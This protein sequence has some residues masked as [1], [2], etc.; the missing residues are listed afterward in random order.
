MLLSE[1]QFMLTPSIYALCKEE[2]F[3]ER[4]LSKG[5][6]TFMLNFLYFTDLSQDVPM[7]SRF[8]NIKY[9]A[10]LNLAL[11]FLYKAFLSVLL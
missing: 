11:I 2:N 1:L 7:I 5:M 4:K 10:G 8:C 6:F 3:L 9:P